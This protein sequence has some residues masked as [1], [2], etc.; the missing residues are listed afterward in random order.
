MKREASDYGGDL[1]K[2]RKGRAR[3]RPLS[4]RETMRLVLR[5]TK[6]KGEH[7]FLRSK[8]DKNAR[9]IFAKFA[10]EY[11]VQI[12]LIANV[13][14]HFYLQIKLLNRFTY[15]AFIR[16]VTGGIAMA[17]MGARTNLR[18]KGFQEAKLVRWL[19]RKRFE[20]VRGERWFRV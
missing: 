19:R 9:R 3:R 8:H 14:N 18:A 11:G 2:T 5:S 13:G 12:P 15:D 20:T 17:V 4:T 7:S 10:Q 6:A 1:L 16:A